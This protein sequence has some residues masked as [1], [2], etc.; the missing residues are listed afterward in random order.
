MNSILRTTITVTLIGITAVAV[1]VGGF[2]AGHFASIPG[3]PLPA[4]AGDTAS[5]DSHSPQSVRNLFAP[6]WETWDLVQAEYV[7]QPVDDVA[8]MQGAIRGML[9]ALE[10]QHTSYMPPEEYRLISAVQDGELEGIGAVVEEAPEG[11]L[12]IVSPMPGSPAEAAGI[13]P[14]D[15]IIAVDGV[16]ITGMSQAQAVNRVRGPAG[17]TVVLTIV[18][19]GHEDELEFSVTRARITIAAVESEMLPG[20]I[21]YIKINDFY[22]G[23]TRQLRDQLRSLQSQGAQGLIVDVRGNP[24]GYLNTAIEVASQ[25]V[26]GGTLI[27][28]EQFGDGRE[29]TYDAQRGGLA[30]DIPLVLLIDHGSASASE[31]LAGAIQ[32]IG[33]GTLIGETTYGKGTVQTWR[34]LRGDNGAVRVTI[35][36]WLTPEG[37]NIAEQ[38]IAPDIAIERTP[39]DV[40][41]G[42]DPQ[43]DEALRQIL[44][45]IGAEAPAAP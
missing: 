20:N 34:E 28:R 45:A 5:A 12:R 9:E 30:T 15:R 26:P 7:E 38:G 40:A 17:S 18:R 2:V 10:D 41:A 33:R 37:R 6:F 23:T 4:L 3:S 1:F 39:D 42:L 25:F 32:D 43:R 27:M 22:G 13:M 8:L 36:R 16:D 44:S 19:E 31:I 29:I 35:A 14:G 21:G 11:G 24:G